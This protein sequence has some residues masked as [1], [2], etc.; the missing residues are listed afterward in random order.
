MK[1]K[2]DSKLK[3][4]DHLTDPIDIVR[5]HDEH[6][7]KPRVGWKYRYRVSAYIEALREEIRQGR[8]RKK[9]EEIVK[10][11]K[12]TKDPNLDPELSQINDGGR[13]VGWTYRYRIRRKLDHLKNQEKGADIFKYFAFSSFI[14]PFVFFIRVRHS[15]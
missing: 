6:G 15:I 11:P 12:K 9:I 5:A 13:K 2:V 8:T 1:S 7:Y 14:F 4:F 3:S 10:K